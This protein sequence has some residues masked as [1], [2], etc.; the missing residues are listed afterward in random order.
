MTFLPLQGT[1]VVDVTSSL[2][3]PTCTQLLASLGA[4]VIK[5]EPP[6]GDHARLWGPPFVGGEGAM[7][8]AANAGKRSLVLD[9]STPE[10][11][12]ELLEL[13][14]RAD[15][16]VQSLRPGAAER[17]GFGAVALRERHPELV[18]CSI[19]AFGSAGPLRDQPGYDPLL[20]AASG[21]MSVT[22]VDGM[23]P[24]RVGVSLIDLSTGLWAALAIVTTLMRGGGATIDVSLYETALWLLSSQIVGYLGTGEV[25]GREGS[26]FAQIAPYQVFA[27]SD[28]GLMV[29]AGNDKLYRAL[30]AVLG[31]PEDDRF[32]TNPD[33]VRNRAALA[34]LIEGRTC[35]W[36][37]EDLLDALVA[38]GVPA[39]PVRNVGEAAEH[40]QT[41][42][43]GIL[44]QLGGLTT[45]AQPFS[46]DGERIRHAAPP[47]T[48]PPP[49][50]GRPPTAS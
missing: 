23:P 26:A 24:V 11:I 10:G 4:D 35:T 9:L 31:L 3:G 34:A 21:I 8:L 7:F 37:T 15:V 30:C 45:V 1:L 17:H 50:A 12:D 22:G 46:V 36:T 41:V 2:A 40:E 13:A 39:S 14:G 32:R 28:G 38:A 43:L 44:Q 6:G 47:P 49:R 27:T 19:G 5:I 18:Y 42:A 48:L 25:P 29:V 20:Q 16:F 33:R